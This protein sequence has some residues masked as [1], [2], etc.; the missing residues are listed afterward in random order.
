MESST[1]DDNVGMPYAIPL[2][3]RRFGTTLYKTRL[4]QP[5]PEHPG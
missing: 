4:P 3:S 1:F 2:D 5:E